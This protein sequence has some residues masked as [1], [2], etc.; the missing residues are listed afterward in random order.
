VTQKK[1]KKKAP[2]AISNLQIP[3][4]KGF[5]PKELEEKNTQQSQTSPFPFSRV[6]TQNNWKK[7]TTAISNLQIPFSKGCDPKS[8]E[9]KN[10]SNLKPPDSLSQGL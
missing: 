7:K 4:L 3:F 5:V 1:W 6:V 2:T 8:L 9:E 10:H